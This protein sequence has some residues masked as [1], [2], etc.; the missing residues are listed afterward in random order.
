MI[1]CN[2]CKNSI[3][4]S[5][6]HSVK[7]NECPF[8]GSQILNNNDLAQCKKISFDL[9]SAGFKETDVYDISIFIYNKYLK[10]DLNEVSSEEDESIYEEKEATSLEDDTAEGSVDEP[11][12][13]SKE[14]HEED[15]YED[16]DE[17]DRVSRLRQLAR[18]NPI[19]NKKGV[20][21]RRV[22]D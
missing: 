16:E 10:P 6:K 4:R 21:V 14:F 15:E 12:D 9:L 8:C 20:S 5:M 11:L 2:N 22:A 18:N 19:L 7:S 13:S 3:K 1:N 17:D